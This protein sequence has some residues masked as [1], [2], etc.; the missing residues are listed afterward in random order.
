GAEPE[1]SAA[2]SSTPAYAS[3]QVLA[4]MRA[5]VQDDVF[6][7]ASISYGLLSEGARPFGDKT[8]LEAHRARL[9]P[10][11][12]EGMPVEVFAV[13][14]RSLAGDRLHRPAFAGEFYRDLLGTGPDMAC[15]MRR[16]LRAGDVGRDVMRRLSFAGVAAAALCAAVLLL[17]AAQNLIAGTSNSVSAER[18]APDV[19]A[20]IVPSAAASDTAA[21]QPLTPVSF[22]PDATGNSDTSPFTLQ[23][24][25]RTSFA[26]GIVTF[27]STALI[28]GSAQSMVAI[29]IKRLQS[30]RGAAAFEWEIESGSARPNIDYEPVT[31]QVVSFR[32]GQSIRSLFIPLV[33]TAANGETRPPRSFT[34]S[35]RSVDGGAR[36]GSV[37]RIKVTIVPQPIY[38]GIGD[39]LARK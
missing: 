7:I 28:A 23:G 16:T 2:E 9:C 17:P 5:E 25:T 27:E 21:S 15:A 20:A 8:S 10:A 4:G 35:L 19:A 30:T 3:P 34:V 6:S 38:S 39:K 29:P 32:D 11:V 12:I 31:P 37:S 26:P 22:S 1:H 24:A 33:R 36:L 14:V 18:M 13:L